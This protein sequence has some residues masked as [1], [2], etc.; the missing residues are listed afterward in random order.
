MN[1]V[2][3]VCGPT[4]SGKSAFA[5]HLA[6]KYGHFNPVIINADSMQLYKDIAI[7][8]AS[9]STEDKKFIPHKLYGILDAQNYC[10]VA[11]YVELAAKSIQDELKAGKLPILVGGTGMYINAL[12]FGY[13][14][15]P[16]IAPELRLQA[17]QKLNTVGNEQ[18][19]KELAI[20]DP[21]AA[22]KLNPGDSQR[23]LRAYEVIRQSGKSI[24]E[25]HA[26][27]PI[28][29]LH[30]IN[31]EVI[32]L[33]PERNFL[34]NSCNERFIELIGK[35]ALQEVKDL[36]EKDLKPDSPVFKALGVKELMDFHA[37]KVL[38][39][40][41]VK[42]AQ[43][44]TRQYAKRQVTWFTHQIKVK[45]VIS[46]DDFAKFNAAIKAFSLNM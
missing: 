1:K 17:R 32:M 14:P 33:N 4:A 45:Q 18:F 5:M 24:L 34:Y 15:I 27:A 44:K 12:M 30:K 11:D 9:P 26:L 40:E 38:L 19:F 3:V 28:Q 37:G 31:F 20:L 46:Y 23:I 16:D 43:T 21:L 13:S 10:S 42:L 29:P 35:G 25:Y 6:Q 2:I 22:E 7:I 39:S 8:A 36:M 41:A